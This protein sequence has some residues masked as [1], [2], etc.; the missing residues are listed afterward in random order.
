M[1]NKK[2]KFDEPIKEEINE[3]TDVNLEKTETTEKTDSGT[4][5]ET[6]AKAQESQIEPK[7]EIGCLKAKCDDYLDKYQRCLAEFDNF[8]KRTSKEK[9]GMYDEGVKDTLLKLLSVMDNLDRAIL[10]REAKDEEDSFLTGVKMILKQL[11]EIFASMDVT[12]IKAVGEKFDPAY[13][14]AVAHE[15]NEEYGENE[16]VFEMLKGYMYKDKVLRHSMVKVAN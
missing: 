10:S 12:E 11:K 2:D 14:E 9:A 1:E 7:D 15:E 3:E 16:I 13:H 8:R 6:Q 4:S 5:E